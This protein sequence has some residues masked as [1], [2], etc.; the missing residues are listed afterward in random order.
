MENI[1]INCTKGKTI[2]ISGYNKTTK[3]VENPEEKD[4]FTPVSPD[5]VLTPFVNT[6]DTFKIKDHVG[7]VNIQS[8][9]SIITKSEELNR[10]KKMGTLQKFINFRKNTTYYVIPNM[11]PSEAFNMISFNRFMAISIAT[12]RLSTTGVAFNWS[13]SGYEVQ[14]SGGKPMKKIT[15]I[16]EGAINKLAM[17][18]GF[19]QDHEYHWFYSNGYEYTFEMYPA[20]VIALTLFKLKHQKELNIKDMDMKQIAKATANQMAKKG[21]VENVLEIV[22]KEEILKQYD[23]ICSG[24]VK[25][26]EVNVTEL[27]NLFKTEFSLDDYHDE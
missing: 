15:D 13:S 11:K 22:S 23:I 9:Y 5:L 4:D 7:G 10:K 25:A 12:I 16:P 27:L 21:K 14:T 18:A 3:K 26:N 6:Q 24:R 20:E 19:A 17:S 2:T 8:A 1:K